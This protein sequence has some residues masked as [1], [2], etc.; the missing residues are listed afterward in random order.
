MA[1]EVNMDLQK[2]KRYVNTS[3]WIVVLLF[4][5][6]FFTNHITKACA[7]LF[8]SGGI[9]GLITRNIPYYRISNNPY[10]KK[11]MGYEKGSIAGPLINVVFIIN[12]RIWLFMPF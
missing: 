12:G 1:W 7:I 8:I 2:K 9:F 10:I 3:V 6:L 5:L 4:L 11:D